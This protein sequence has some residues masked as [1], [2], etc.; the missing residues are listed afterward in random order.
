M[1]NIKFFLKKIFSSNFRSKLKKLHRKLKNNLFKRN[2]TKTSIQEIKNF[3]IKKLGISSGDNLIIS[4][5]FGNLNA[6]FSPHELIIL[7]QELVGNEGNLVMPFY[8]PGNSYEWAESGQT[9]DMRNTRSSM[10]IVT[11]VFSEMPNVYKSKHP[12][13]AVVAWGKN[14]QE[15]TADHE[16]S[17]T[18]FFWDSPYGWLIKHNSKSLGLGLK[19]IPIFHAIEDIILN[20]KLSLYQEKKKRLRII[21]YKNTLSEINV[22]VHDPFKIMKL[23][24]AG[25]YVYSLNLPSYKR[26]KIGFTFCYIV[27]NQEL[28]EVCKY[29]FGKG[30]FRKKKK[31]I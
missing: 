30:N 31:W 5:S 23:I 12:T 6:I 27:N 14:A 24:D 8:P 7:L 9:F 4:S 18:P 13:K 28:F 17:T 10:G 29:E 22:F 26:K 21:D 11:Q 1:I 2:K 19:N 15:I 3:L 20:K 25:D 16:N